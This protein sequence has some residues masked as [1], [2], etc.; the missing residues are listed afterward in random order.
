[1]REALDQIRLRLD[2]I[3][4]ELDRLTED[5]VTGARCL[6]GRPVSSGSAGVKF[7]KFNVEAI[8]GTEAEGGAATVATTGGQVLAVIADGTAADSTKDYLIEMVGRAYV[9]HKA[10]C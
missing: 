2:E 9:A 6:L 4:A 10:A 7:V 5:E 3:E 8:T 1:M